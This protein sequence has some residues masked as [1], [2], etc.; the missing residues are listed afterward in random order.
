MDNKDA[1]Q[2]FPVKHWDGDRG[3]FIVYAN[4]Y[5]AIASVLESYINTYPA[6]RTKPVGAPGSQA[7]DEQELKIALEDAARAVL[8]SSQVSHG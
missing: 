4:H 3:C 5:D 7:R 2:A 8:K 6:F 1:K